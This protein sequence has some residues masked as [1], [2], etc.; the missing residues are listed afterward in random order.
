MRNPF[1]FKTAPQG[2]PTQHAATPSSQAAAA[3]TDSPTAAPGD[4]F[5]GLKVIGFVEKDGGTRAVISHHSSVYL[6]PK[7][8][9]FENTFI[10]VAISADA[11]EVQNL[12]TQQAS[13]I[14]YAP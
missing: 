5:A 4:G 11:V 13:W 1:K 9:T 8:G 10:V 7:G 14:H 6:V 2:P 3:V 12:Q